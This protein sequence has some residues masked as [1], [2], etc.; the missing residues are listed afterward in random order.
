MRARCGWQRLRVGVDGALQPGGLALDLC[1][2][3]KGHA[4]DRICARLADLGLDA[5]LVDIGGEL[6]GHGVKPDGQPWWVALEQPPG[7]DT[8]GCVLAAHDIAVATSGDY[9]RCWRDAH[10][11]L[12]S[13]TI[14]PRCGVPIEHG[15]AS[16][17]VVHASCMWADAWS[18]A[19]M[20]L[21]PDKGLA[22]AER[23][24]LAARFIIRDARTGWRLAV[25]SAWLALTAA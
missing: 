8:T 24:R 19:L 22:L 21:G 6:R 25:S 16:V 15:V 9:R 12:R 23:Q 17:S 1:A 10:G 20:V 7:C 11:R 3:A 13:H 4:V 2:I 5:M 14:D 18:T